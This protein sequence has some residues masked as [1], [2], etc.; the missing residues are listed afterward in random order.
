MNIKSSQTLVEEAKKSIETLSVH[1]AKDLSDKQEIT[2]I[3]VRDIRELWKEGT[4]ENS[5]HIPRGMLEFWLDPESS[6]YKA[7]KIKDIKKMVLFCALGWRSALATKSLVDM[8]FK[9]VAHVDGGFDALKKSG[10][11]VIEKKKI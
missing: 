9:N 5:K 6:Y 2:L 10:L 1:E 4:I 8:G 7:N 11:K 3:D